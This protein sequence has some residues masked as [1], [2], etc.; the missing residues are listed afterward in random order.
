MV[1]ENDKKK[2]M[3]KV[4][5]KIRKKRKDLLKN[6]KMLK[7]F[8]HKKHQENLVFYVAYPIAPENA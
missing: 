3:N 8:K 4:Y 2:K 1:G 7:N 6:Q 5:I